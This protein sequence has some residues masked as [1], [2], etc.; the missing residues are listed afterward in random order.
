MSNEYMVETNKDDYFN[1]EIQFANVKEAEYFWADNKWWVKTLAR[2]L[3]GGIYTNA[4]NINTPFV[5]MFMGTDKVLIHT[6]PEDE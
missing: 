2:T 3:E 6:I 4:I 1:T 5:G